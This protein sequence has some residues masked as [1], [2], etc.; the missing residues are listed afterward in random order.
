MP[1]KLI[2][3]RAS[4]SGARQAR[5]YRDAEWDEYV[6]KFDERMGT[7]WI[8]REAADYHT[9]DKQDALFMAANWLETE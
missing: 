1:R 3:K 2:Q 7:A 6:V 5:V 9:S 8:H 4:A